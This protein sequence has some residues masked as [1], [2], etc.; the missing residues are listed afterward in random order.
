MVIGLALFGAG[1]FAVVEASQAGD[2]ERHV[3]DMRGFGFAPAQLVVSAGDTIVWINRD[4]VPHT[5]TSAVGAWDSGEMR[6]N[7][8]WGWVPTEA[9]A[10]DYVCAYHPGMRGT[11]TVRS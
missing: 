2:A 5:A 9:G 3:I 7:A 6:T 1:L 4:V 8:S 11:I 10:V